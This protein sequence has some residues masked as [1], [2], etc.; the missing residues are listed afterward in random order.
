MV[1]AYA[2]DASPA[3]CV[4]HALIEILPARPAVV[5]SGINYGANLSTEVTLS[6]TVGAALEAAAFGLPALAVS[7][8]M[9]Q[10][11][12]LTGEEA[13]SF[14]AAK[15]YT[16]HF[17]YELMRGSTPYD[18]HVLNLNVPLGASVDCGW[19]STRLSRYRYLEPTKPDRAKG[20][21]RPSYR[22]IKHPE[23]TEHDSDI[24]A[25]LVD[26]LVS[27]TP[28]SLDLTSRGIASNPMWQMSM[29]AIEGTY[30]GR[31]V[32]RM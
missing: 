17:C 24:R 26:R 2:I 10:A 23:M 4:I 7:Q 32:A 1:P 30:A 31:A 27:M 18:V 5:V 28:L 16:A 9:H 19:R 20:E 12:F 8:E 6:G 21:G 22:I 29:S 14:A 15:R 13:E 25:V 11:L 3:Q